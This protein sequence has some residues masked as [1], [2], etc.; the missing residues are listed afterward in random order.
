MPLR[1]DWGITEGWGGGAGERE[2]N[3]AVLQ[4]SSKLQL[5]SQRPHHWRSMDK[6]AA[7]YKKLFCSP[8]PFLRLVC[9][10]RSQCPSPLRW[11]PAD[12]GPHIATTCVGASWR[13]KLGLT[14]SPNKQDW[15]E[16]GLDQGSIILKNVLTPLVCHQMWNLILPG[17]SSSQRLVNWPRHFGSLTPKIATAGGLFVIYS[18]SPSFMIWQYGVN[19]RI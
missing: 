18:N 7:L 10:R 19:T 13:I 15:T 5:L 4:L 11:W 2:D 12:V 17:C 9:W 8:G 16:A 6:E 3:D 14:G 1:Q